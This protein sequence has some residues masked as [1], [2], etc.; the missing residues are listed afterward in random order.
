M[1][2]G[3]ADVPLS[4][5]AAAAGVSRSTLLHLLSGP[6]IARHVGP[7]NP[8]LDQTCAMFAAAF[9]QAVATSEPAAPAPKRRARSSIETKGGQP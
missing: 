1:R 4:V 9:V 6:L 5:L 2:N 3:V 8:D 7:E